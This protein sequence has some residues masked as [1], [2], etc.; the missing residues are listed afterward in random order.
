GRFRDIS[1]TNPALCGSY[2]V[3]RS[4]ACG[5]VDG[6]GAL[7][8]VVTQVAGPAKLYRN[9]IPRK[10][11]WLMVR[12]LDPALRS[13]AYGAES[14]VVTE[15]RGNPGPKER[16]GSRAASSSWDAGPWS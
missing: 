8:L 1:A 2:G 14:R 15:C 7:D 13:D 12:A 16:L 11:H 4:M 10:G 6:D 9:V 5:D 3:H